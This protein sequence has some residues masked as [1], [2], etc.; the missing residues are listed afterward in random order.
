MRLLL[1]PGQLLRLAGTLL[2]LTETGPNPAQATGP[3]PD[4]DVD[5]DADADADE[6]H[7]RLY[8]CAVNGV[9]ILRS[10]RHVR[11]TD[12]PD[13]GRKTNAMWK[14]PSGAAT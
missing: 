13:E 4:A 8:A 9:L 5:A 1:R 10:W 6:W 3:R 14:H 11:R 2:H 7:E 12:R